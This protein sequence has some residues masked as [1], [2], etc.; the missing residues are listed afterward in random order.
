MLKRLV[1]TIQLN[2]HFSAH[3]RAEW[4]RK[5]GIF[6]EMGENVSIQLHKIPLYPE[7]ISFHNNIVIASGVSFATHDAIHAVLNRIPGDKHFVE[8]IGC[9]EIM[10]NCFIGANTVIL[11]NVRIGPNVIIAA[12]SIITKDVPPNSV[13]GGVPAK[14]IGSFD[15][16]AKKREKMQL[17][18]G[19]EAPYMQNMSTETAEYYWRK[20]RQERE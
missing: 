20:F 18:P 8:N 12:G 2:L 5:K 15:E 7:C 16:I 9:I 1:Q 10:D 3:K 19:I 13:V 6:H 14:V 11:P 17:D 4:M